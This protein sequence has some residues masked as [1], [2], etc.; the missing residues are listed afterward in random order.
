MC[1]VST[2][3]SNSARGELYR[4]QMWFVLGTAGLPYSVRIHRSHS[5]INT[6]TDVS[7]IFQISRLRH[8]FI[9]CVRTVHVICAKLRSNLTRNKT[10]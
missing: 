3:G 2:A 7:Q 5:F 9:E 10:G 8:I 1:L 6:N 4:Q